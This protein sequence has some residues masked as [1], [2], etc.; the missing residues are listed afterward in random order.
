MQTALPCSHP[1]I[2]GICILALVWKIHV[3][4][5]KIAL[6]ESS[7]KLFLMSWRPMRPTAIISLKKTPI[8]LGINRLK[9]HLLRLNES[10]KKLLPE[11][12]FHD[13]EELCRKICKLISTTIPWYM[14]WI[15]S[16]YLFNEIIVN[17]SV[18]ESI[19]YFIISR[20]IILTVIATNTEFSGLPWIT[21]LRS[22]VFLR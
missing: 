6:H 15:C 19:R 17:K 20:T 14:H 16:N 3:N 18:S 2:Y 8:K 11:V 7:V 10:C 21:T 12:V 22:S 5:V 4:L 13:Y 1:N 9:V